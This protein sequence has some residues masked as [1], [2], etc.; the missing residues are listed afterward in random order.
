MKNILLTLP[1]LV[2]LP[3]AALAQSVLEGGQVHGNFQ[4]DGAYYLTDDKLDVTDKTLDGKYFR[5]NAFGNF[6]YT[7]KNFEAGMRF[8]AY[9]PPL[10][11]FD[12]P[13]A[14]EG[15][16]VPYFYAKYKWK[17]LEL[18]AGNFYEQ[19]G[20][21]LILRTYDEWQLG[22]DNSLRGFR[23]K[24][25][26][27]KGMTLT[28]L[29]GTQRYYWEP[30]QNGNRGIVRGFDADLYLND[31]IPG[32]SDKKLQISIGG[33]F[34]SKY[35]KKETK[36]IVKDTSIYQYKLPENVAAYAGRIN[37]SYGRFAFGAEYAHKMSDPAAYNNNSLGYIYREGEALLV[38]LS[39]SRRGLGISLSGKRIDNMA[40]KSSRSEQGPVLDI[41]YLPA[42]TKQQTY[43]LS[44]I[45]PYATQPNGEMGMQAAIMYTIPKKSKLGGKYGTKIE[46]NYS[47][48]YSLNKTRIAPDIPI[49]STGTKGYNSDF[50]KVGD[51]KYFEEI[52]V[53]ITKKFNRKFKSIFSYVYQAYNQDVIEQKTG[54]PMV[55]ANIGIADLTYKITPTKSLRFEVQHMSTKQDRGDWVMGLLEFNIAPKWFFTIMDEYNYGNPVEDDKIH[56][57][58][59]NI[60]FV[61]G[62]TRIS[63]AYGRQREGLLCVG[64][65]CRLVPASNGFTITISSQF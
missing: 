5:M 54:V 25:S 48:I 45:Y 12:P 58:N 46:F 7:N 64:G 22:Y 6:I 57:Y 35:E 55:Y 19:F 37:L 21:G 62:P 18:T 31:L 39:Y 41:N 44:T 16:G 23:A 51:D 29:I 26:P 53:V 9:L 34:V 17:N 43:S 4:L 11:G 20:N 59:A 32:L 47:N 3:V 52:N 63:M 38:N 15:A 2:L 40:Y 30:Y 28:G 10:A 8:E 56:Y 24:Y 1:I 33:S 49:D 65:V 42:L 14:Y 13:S 36:T 27:F 60:A 50:F 61:Q